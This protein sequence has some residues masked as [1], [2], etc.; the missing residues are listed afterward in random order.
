MSL[1]LRTQEQRLLFEEKKVVGKRPHDVDE[2]IKRDRATHFVSSIIYGGSI[3]IELL[4]KRVELEKVESI[5]GELAVQLEKL[6]GSIDLTGN[7]KVKIDGEL[8]SLNETFELKVSSHPVTR[9]LFIH[10]KYLTPPFQSFSG[11]R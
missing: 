10:W 1:F 5:K 11:A 2:I 3:I 7:A 8:K 9:N 6:K 4:S